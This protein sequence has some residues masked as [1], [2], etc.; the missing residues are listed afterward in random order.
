[1][2]HYSNADLLSLKM[3]DSLFHFYGIYFMPHVL[4]LYLLHGTGHFFVKY[5]AK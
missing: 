5:K 3:L 4:S 2:Q 1:M